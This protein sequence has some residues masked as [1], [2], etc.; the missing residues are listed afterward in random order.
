MA[1]LP[2]DAVYI[3]NMDRATERMAEMARQ[4]EA[5]G[6]PYVRVPA[7]DGSKV[8]DAVLQR[9]ATPACRRF[10]TASMVGCALS[11]MS[12]WRAAVA[13]GH[14]RVLVLEDDA[15]LVDGFVDKL[16]QALEDVPQ[17]FDVL[18]GGCYFLC[19]KNRKYPLGH[20]VSRLFVP[21][22]LR[23][24]TRTWGSVFVPEFFG[25]THCYV[26]SNTGCKRL[27]KTIPLVNYHID[28][29]MNH[30]DLHLYAVSPDLARQRDMSDS[31]IA[32]YAFPKTLVPMLEKVKDQKHIS[33]AYYLDAPM[34]Q[35]G[36]QRVNTWAIIFLA[37]GALGGPKAA[38]YALGL[39]AAEFVVGGAIIVPLVCFFLGWGFR[40]AWARTY[41]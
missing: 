1:T 38:P 36:G 9:V 20:E 33:L 4:C 25:G 37:T 31:S 28:M 23:S 35:I 6:I 29:S 41:T 5:L 17:D 27:F 7:V 12:V 3:I 15:V 40:R 26:V 10:C 11:H 14:E 21:H 39:L 22:A 19:D 8:S 2:V 24:D 16:R 13:A 34:M 30:P 32:S 18:V